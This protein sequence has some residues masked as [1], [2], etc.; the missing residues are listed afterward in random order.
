MFEKLLV[1]ENPS[2]IFFLKVLVLHKSSMEFKDQNSLKSA[3]FFKNH[4]TIEKLKIWTK[5]A[6]L[7]KNDTSIQIQKYC[8]FMQK[9]HI[10]HLSN[11]CTV[12]QNLLNY[13]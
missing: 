2:Q 12:I 4:S 7:T 11:N 8:T 10:Y 5:T 6:H 3:S 1:Q 13:P 9:L